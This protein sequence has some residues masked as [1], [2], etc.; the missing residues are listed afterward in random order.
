[1]RWKSVVLAGAFGPAVA[2]CNVAY[3][4]ARNIVND[5]HVVMT[6]QAIGHDLRKAARSAWEE[7][8]GQYPHC[9]AEFQDGF[10]DGYVDYL[11]RGGN[12]S[13]PAV[14]P[15]KYTRHQKYF[16]ENGHC[17]LKEYF[18]GFKY[19]QEVAIATGRRQ[20]LTVPVLFPPVPPTPPAFDV[21]PPGPQPMMT[22]PKPPPGMVD[23]LAS[24]AKDVPVV[25]VPPAPGPAPVLQLRPP[26]RRLAK[27][28]PPP[29]FDPVPKP[30]PDQD[31]LPA[32]TPPL[33]VPSASSVPPMAPVTN[34]IP[35]LPPNHTVPP[36]LPPNHPQPRN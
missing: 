6:Q 7:A 25:V 16:T 21:V 13:L 5:P 36:P 12:G 18:L 26:A 35:V 31:R 23:P 33:P 11:D 24:A 2:G 15:A 34:P 1:M 27:D 19:G 28:P 14:P 32:P 29:E 10:E 30:A 22:P 9:T 20:F 8:R 4:A 3:N 17:L